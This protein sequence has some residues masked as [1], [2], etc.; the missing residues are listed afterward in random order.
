MRRQIKEII[1]LSLYNKDEL[2]YISDSRLLIRYLKKLDLDALYDPILNSGKKSKL[3]TMERARSERIRQARNVIIAYIMKDDNTCDAKMQGMALDADS[4]FKLHARD[5][6]IYPFMGGG[7]YSISKDMIK[8]CKSIMSIDDAED[9]I[10][11]YPEI[12]AKS[13]DMS[14]LL[15]VKNLT[16]IT[17]DIYNSKNK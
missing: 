11:Q 2:L 4:E 1:D 12:I 13:A 5:L 16:N 14:T 17:I 10:G 6:V 8:T 3:E 9:S 7:K 15:Y